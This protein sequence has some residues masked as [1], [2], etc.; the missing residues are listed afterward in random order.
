MKRLPV[1]RRAAALLL[2][3]G[4]LA[5]VV[6]LAHASPTAQVVTST[7]PARSRPTV[8]WVFKE[9][10][11]MSCKSATYTLRRLRGRL[12]QQVD[13]VAVG[14]GVNES[15]GRAFLRAQ[16]LDVQFASLSESAIQARYRTAAE[17]GL[18]VL[19]GN[20]VVQSFPAGVLRRYPDPDLLSSAV[21]GL[22]V[23]TKA[24]PIIPSRRRQS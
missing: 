21:E 23:S 4:V 16:R 24:P 1:P 8:L 6:L 20:H 12:G 15:S 5:T 2:A 7:P 9:A 18:Y 11:L 22:L 13:V 3:N 19:V 17:P 14:L 10:D